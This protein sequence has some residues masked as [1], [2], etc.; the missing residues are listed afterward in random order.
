MSMYFAC[1]NI[2]LNVRL[3]AKVAASFFHVAKT[4]RCI[5]KNDSMMQN[6]NFFPSH[7]WAVIRSLLS[8]VRGPGT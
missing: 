2:L 8:A 7:V 3:L 4:D 1:K 6:P 5:S